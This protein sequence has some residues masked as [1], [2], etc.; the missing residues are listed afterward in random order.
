MRALIDADRIPYCFGGLKDEEGYPQA[1]EILSSRIDDNISSLV[2][3]TGASDYTLYLTSDDKSNFRFSVAT[4][5][6]YKGSRKAAKPFWYEQIRRY[7]V[8][9]Y[10][11]QIVTGIE[12]D[13]A[14]GIE[15]VRN[16]YVCVQQALGGHS[17]EQT[18]ICSVDKDLDM[19]PGLHYNELKPEKGVYEISERSALHNFY[20]QL[21]TGDD[22]DDIPGLYGV[23][24]SSALLKHINGLSE[25]HDMYLVVKDEY[26]KRFGSYWKLFMYEN[27]KLLW[28]LRSYNSNEIIEMFEQIEKEAA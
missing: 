14:L 3:S 23:G 27:A 2:A 5:V 10:K 18:V 21:L 13:D 12:A 16:N 25:S 22:V 26:V 8:H 17:Y 1:W 9:Q 28:I 19:I 4:I 24:K 11:A 20:G 15:Q 7:L 6:P